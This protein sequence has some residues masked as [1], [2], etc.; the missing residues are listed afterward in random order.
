MLRCQHEPQRS[1]V[2]LIPHKCEDF[3]RG[4]ISAASSG[5]TITMPDS[6]AITTKDDCFYQCEAQH[7]EKCIFY[8]ATNLVKVTTATEAT[9]KSCFM[10]LSA[11]FV[12]NCSARLSEVPATTSGLFK[13]ITVSLN[14]TATNLSMP[15][16]CVEKVQSALVSMKKLVI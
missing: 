1:T 16:H 11:N 9:Y 13:G 3:A 10:T 14:L 2:S 4:T 6:T 7:F 12:T 15:N 5:V 8:G